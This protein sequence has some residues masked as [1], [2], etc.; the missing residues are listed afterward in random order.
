MTP[1]D[2]ITLWQNSG[3]WSPCVRMALSHVQALPTKPRATSSE[4]PA[5]AHK[6]T[7][8]VATPAVRSRPR[9]R[10]PDRRAKRSEHTT[11][12]ARARTKR[13]P[14]SRA[15]RG[16]RYRRGER[17]ET[18]RSDPIREGNEKETRRKGNRERNDFRVHAPAEEVETKEQRAGDPERRDRR[19][20]ARAAVLDEL[21]IPDD[22]GVTWEWRRAATGMAQQT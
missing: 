2:A 22:T 14:S 16:S 11:N 1:Y 4:C 7:E 10:R 19:E 8:L 6:E 17:N 12:K 5:V 20:R 21:V 15:G 3:L 18:I 9:R 13:L